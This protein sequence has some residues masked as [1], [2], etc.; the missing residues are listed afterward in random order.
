MQHETVSPNYGEREGRGERVCGSIQ[1]HK[2]DQPMATT[3]NIVG[4]GG[5]LYA[6]R[7]ISVASFTTPSRSRW[8][9]KESPISSARSKCVRGGAKCL[10]LFRH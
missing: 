6:D 2:V 4:P 10:T 7:L 5:Q 9:F 8:N 3:A 1:L